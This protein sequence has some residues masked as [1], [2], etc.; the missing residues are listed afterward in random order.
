MEICPC[1]LKQFKQLSRH[2]SGNQN[3]QLYYDN[4][5]VSKRPHNQGLSQ[6]IR[7]RVQNRVPNMK[8]GPVFMDQTRMDSNMTFKNLSSSEECLL[9]NDEEFD[10]TAWL[11]DFGVEENCIENNGILDNSKR[12]L[13]T[14]YKQML[15]NNNQ[16]LSLDYE[17][18]VKLL[19]ILIDIDAPLYAFKNHNGLRYKIRIIGISVQF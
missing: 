6:S 5:I 18:Y 17:V 19:K 11:A 2:L 16:H 12:K 10:K 15:L 13:F 14:K 1:C 9:L 3:C 4:N 7:K 8:I